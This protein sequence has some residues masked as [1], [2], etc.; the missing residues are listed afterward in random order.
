MRKAIVLVLCVLL[1]AQIAFA[2]GILSNSNHS[3]QYVRMLSRGATTD[4]DAVH[5][6]PAGLVHLDQGLT[7]GLY[8]QTIMQTRSVENDLP[9]LNQNKFDGDLF[10]PVFP[11]FYAAF[12]TN[13]LVLSFGFGPNAGG[14]SAEFADG[15]PSFEQ[16]LAVLP[17]MISAMGLPTTA[18]SADI[19]FNGSSIFYGFQL[20][21]SY[22][23][24]E[25]LGVFVGGRYLMAQNT[26][27][28]SIKNV[29]INPQHPLV[30][31]TGAMMSASQFFTMI[32]QPAFAAM[33]SD[34]AVDATQTGSAITPIVGINYMFSDKVN[35]GFKYEGP[36][37]LELENETK[38]DDV[39]MFA[40]GEKSRSDLPAIYSLGIDYK[41][42][43]G[44]TLS[45]TGTYYFDKSADWNGREDYVKDS[46]WELNFGAEYYLNPGLAVSV[47]YNKTQVTV[48]DDFQS[49]LAHNLSSNSVGFGGRYWLNSKIAIDLGGVI[50]FYDPYEEEGVDATTS[51]PFMQTYDRES[52]AGAI[53]LSYRF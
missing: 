32:E 20:G 47:G 45:G 27:E 44:L 31:P 38:A 50:T 22:A 2:G 6:N 5:Y 1:S 39:G 46:T 14:G 26:Y 43:S 28:G 52:I 48:E 21:A 12:K 36:T 25:E 49:D 13:K 18:Y 11:N 35:V 16:Q 24:T 3:A 10:A 30:N 23:V 8:N 4:I 37:E 40:D 53:G 42:I 15:L 29:Q 41:P 17:P 51:L 33:T 7:L 9:L 34:L 19:E